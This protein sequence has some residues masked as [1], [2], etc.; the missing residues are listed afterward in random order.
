V[1]PDERAERVRQP[2]DESSQQ[3]QQQL[4]LQQQQQHLHPHRLSAEDAAARQASAE[5]AE[6]QRLHRAEHATVVDTLAGMFPGLDRD[7]ISDVVYQK[8]GR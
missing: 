6:A 1:S 5:A 7:L 3:Q 8:Q 2:R 4:Q